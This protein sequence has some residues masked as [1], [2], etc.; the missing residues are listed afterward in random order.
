[1]LAQKIVKLRRGG[2][3]PPNRNLRSAA[4]RIPAP[5]PKG[6]KTKRFV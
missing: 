5:Q 6:K 4:G 1:M 3:I 2:A